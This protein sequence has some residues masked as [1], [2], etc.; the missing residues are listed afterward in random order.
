MIP[1]PALEGN[2][3]GCDSS[4]TKKKRAAPNKSPHRVQQFLSVHSPINNLLP[5]G[6]HQMKAAHHRLFRGEALRTAMELRCSNDGVV[7]TAQ[8]SSFLVDEAH[9]EP[10]LNC[11][12]AAGL[13]VE[14]K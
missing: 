9:L 12:A 4:F 5:A 10:G 11:W 13:P 14:G 2:G 7:D 3:K 1:S 6:R 8:R